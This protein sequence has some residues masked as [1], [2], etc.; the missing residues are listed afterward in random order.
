MIRITV[1]KIGSVSKNVPL[2]KELRIAPEI[3]AKEGYLV[4]G[5]IIGQKTKYNTLESCDGRMVTLHD[6]DIIVG[7]FGHR[8]ALHGYSGVVPEAVSIGDILNILNIGGVVGRCTSANPSIGPPFGLEVMGSVLVF[9]ELAQRK[10][11]PAHIGMNSINPAGTLED[12]K[13]TPIIVVA[14]TCMN[15]GKTFAACEI[16]RHL[17][18]KGFRVAGCKLSG[19]SLLRDTLNMQDHGALYTSSFN[20]AGIVTTNEQNSNKGARKTLQH[21]LETDAQVIIAELGDGI[22]GTYG[23]QDILS[24]KAVQARTKAI[25]LCANDPVGAWGGQIFL[26]EH[27][28]IAADVVSGP[29]T[30]HNAGSNFVQDKVGI[31]GIN[32]VSHGVD[33]AEFLLKKVGL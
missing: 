28:N 20:D 3:I 5:R 7:A 19:V 22:M 26:R 1:D 2:R 12:A 4:C 11:I 14:G 27:F 25:V 16:I 31:P 29:V 23:V 24:D 21:L 8:N 18:T 6:G 33:L 15:S 30:D 13:K 10:G 32:A 17:H 9:P